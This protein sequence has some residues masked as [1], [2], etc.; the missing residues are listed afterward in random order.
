MG[1]FVD[2]FFQAVG[3]FLHHLH[4]IVQDIDPEAFEWQ[5]KRHASVAD[6]CLF[7]SPDVAVRCNNNIYSAEQALP[8]Q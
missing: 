6:N 2:H 7:K 5:I 3:V 1:S 4:N 8:S